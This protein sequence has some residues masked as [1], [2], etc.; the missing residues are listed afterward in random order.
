MLSI[1]IGI[2]V[3]F[4]SVEHYSAGEMEWFILLLTFGILDIIT[5]VIIETRKKV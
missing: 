5:G 3:I 1:I 2:M 4:A